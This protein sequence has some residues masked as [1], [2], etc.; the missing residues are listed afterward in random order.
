MQLFGLVNALLSTDPET[1]QRDLSIQ[2]YSVT[3]L[4]HNV[5]IVGWVPFCDTIHTLIKG[6]RQARKILLN[7]EHR[8]MVGMAPMYDHLTLI[9]TVEVFEMALENTTGQDLYKVLWLKSHSAEVW[10][11][12]RTNY[13][14]SLAVMSM[15]GYILGLGDRHTANLMLERH[16][17]KIVHIDFGDCFEVAIHRKRHPETIPFRLTRMLVQAM[18]VSGIEGTFRFTCEAVMRVLR[19]VR[20]SRVGGD[21][22]HKGRAAYHVRAGPAV[23]HVV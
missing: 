4:S 13:T 12:R 10:L 15:V 23:C 21:A 8:L 11:E 7:I 5:G 2:R 1:S 20:S 16:S 18:E 22:C 14:Q 3:P 9:Q 19:E 17:G 6:F